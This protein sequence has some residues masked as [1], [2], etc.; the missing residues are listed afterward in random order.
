MLRVVGFGGATVVVVVVLGVSVVVVVEVVVSTGAFVD[1]S[2][3]GL[4][5]VESSFC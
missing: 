2:F 5:T 1:F 3:G 4:S